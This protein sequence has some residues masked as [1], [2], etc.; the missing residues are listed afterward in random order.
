[1]MPPR[2]QGAY[3]GR[4]F[5]LAAAVMLM[6]LAG[7]G[8][9]F[10]D[11][12]D[13]LPALV[14]LDLRPA[15]P[16]PASA[17]VAEQPAGRAFDQANR[18]R[19]RISTSAG[20][21]LDVTRDIQ[22]GQAE[23][24]LPLRV[25]LPSGDV[26]AMVEVTLFLIG[27]PLFQGNASAT[28]QRGRPLDLTIPLVGQPA[29]VVV[30]GPT[31]PVTALQE[32]VQF[33]AQALFAT[34]DAIPGVQFSWGTATPNILQPLGGGRFRT[35]GEGTGQVSAAVGQASGFGQV[36]VAAVPTQLT[37]EPPSLD[38]IVGEEV[39]LVARVTDRNGQLLQRTV[40][41]V[42]SGPQVASVTPQGVVRGQSSG[43]ALVRGTAGPVTATIPVQV[44]VPLPVVATLPAGEVSGGQATLN[45]TVNPNGFAA[46]GWFEYSLT[47]TFAEVA[48]T[49]AVSVG[50]GRSPVAISALT[51]RLL[52]GR[53]YFYRAVGRNS[54][55]EVRGG[56]QS[57]QT[58]G[59]PG[60]PV[61]VRYDYEFDGSD[62]LIF[63]IFWS[64]GAGVVET[65]EVQRAPEVCDTFGCGPGGWAPLITLPAAVTEHR[66]NTGVFT[67]QWYYYRVRACNSVGCS[68]FVE[69][70]FS[71]GAP[72]AGSGSRWEGSPIGNGSG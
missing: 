47:S 49:P 54:F 72:P 57:F 9:F 17:D 21:L 11:A 2:L 66:D 71:G 31:G 19:V 27:I 68:A 20:P 45:G 38:L 32:E 28:L 6:A 62:D 50:D 26:Q 25:D 24:R 36:V 44:R 52:P 69:A 33:N 13:P 67:E 55:G 8:D 35:V 16:P 53:I 18:V 59:P 34:G 14:A 65:Y 1:M 43:N 51:D 37:I 22:P 30:T 39:T 7:C 58:P 5:R 15:G 56:V 40:T 3:R 48:T 46:T 29:Q 23:I 64:A 70:S 60:A 63:D 42:S 41:W 12:A 4:G 10:H 61:N